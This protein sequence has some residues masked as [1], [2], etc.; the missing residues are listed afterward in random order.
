V[1]GGSSLSPSTTDGNLNTNYVGAA[2]SADWNFGSGNFTIDFWVQVNNGSTD[3]NTNGVAFIWYDGG[4][5]ARGFRFVLVGGNILFSW[6]TDGSTFKTA[7]FAQTI[8]ASTFYHIALVRNGSSLLLFVNGSSVTNTGTGIST[9]TI[10]NANVPLTVGGAYSAASSGYASVNGYI[11]EVRVSNTARWTS[12]FTPPG[13][14]YG[15]DYALTLVAGSFAM[16]GKAAT[17]LKGI[18]YKIAAVAGGYAVTGAANAMRK[19][20][21]IAAI[22]GAYSITGAS[23]VPIKRMRVPALAGSYAVTGRATNMVKALRIVASAGSYAFTFPLTITAY[24]LGK[25]NMIRKAKFVLEKLRTNPPILE[26]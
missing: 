7:T 5:G 13:A 26:Q 9:D 19:A 17:L 3:R 23:S 24:A 8:S 1:F 20:M 2:A 6:T 12:N 25:P 21:R 22:A 4:G 11:D 14:A 16:S 10:F 15:I 18:A